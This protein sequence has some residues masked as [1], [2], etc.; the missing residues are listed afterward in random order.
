MKIL[1][2]GL[3]LKALISIKNLHHLSEMNRIEN[4]GCFKV[5]AFEIFKKKFKMKKVFENYHLYECVT[6]TEF[7]R[8]FF[9]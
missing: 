8:H 3:C 7:G 2:V 9:T 6:F 1:S 4:Y 5:V